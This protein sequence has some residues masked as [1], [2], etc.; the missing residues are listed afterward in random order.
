MSALL[1][2][3]QSLDKELF[4]NVLKLI[5]PYE[6]LNN[7][8]LANGVGYISTI[9]NYNLDEAERLIERAL[10]KGPYNAAYLDSM[11]YVKYK[12]GNYDTAAKYMTKALQLVDLNTGCGV[13]FEHAG[14][15]EQARNNFKS[16]LKFYEKALK[17]GEESEDFKSENVRN[18]IKSIKK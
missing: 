6:L 9:L 14:D 18:K 3:E 12:K 7:P 13:L 5:P 10:I 11:A 16:A 15:I 17:Y 1:A 4:I 8:I 2:A